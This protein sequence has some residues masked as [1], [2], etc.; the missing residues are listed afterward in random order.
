M[1]PEVGFHTMSA[2][3]FFIGVI[4]L[5]R[6]I[7]AEVMVLPVLQVLRELDLIKKHQLAGLVP[8]MVHGSLAVRIDGVVGG[9]LDLTDTAIELAV[10]RDN[11]FTEQKCHLGGCK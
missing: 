7:W 5:A 11:M 8:R 1:A 3:N 6:T 9:V 2:E 4:H 10:L